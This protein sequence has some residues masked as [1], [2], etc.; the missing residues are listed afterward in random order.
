MTEA[1]KGTVALVQGDRIFP[2]FQAML[3][4][5]IAAAP[6]RDRKSL[7]RGV[8]HNSKRLDDG[9]WTWRYDSMRKGDGFEGLWDDVPRLDVPTTLVRGANSAFVNDDD[10]DEFAR[11]APGFRG[12][13]MVENSGPLGAE[14]SAAGADRHPA[15][16]PRR[17]SHSLAPS[18][19]S[20]PCRDSRSSPARH[21]SGLPCPCSTRAQHDDNNIDNP[22]SRWP[23]GGN[24]TARPSVVAVWKTDGQ[25]GL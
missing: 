17:L 13:R 19:R 2:S 5:T 4:V 18:R 9:T 6:H 11:T 25:I 16:D 20:R 3:D 14:R 8:F 15:R 24:G 23:E 12:V 10:A 7:R 22:L 21:L 1:Q